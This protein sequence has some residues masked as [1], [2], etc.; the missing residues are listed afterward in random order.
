MRAVVM[1]SFGGEEVLQLTEVADPPAAPGEAL[2]RVGAVEVS[3]TRDIA[4]RTGRHPFSA[5]VSLPHVLGGDFTGTVEAIGPG[6]SPELLGRRVAVANSTG[7]GRCPACRAGREDQCPQLRMLGIHRWGS[8]AEIVSTPAASLSPIPDDLPLATAAAMAATGPIALTQLRTGGV[9]AGSWLVVTGASGAL[10]TMLAVLARH[11]G[12]RVIGLSRRPA[13]IPADAGLAV[14]LDSE[15]DDLADAI[16]AHTG[17]AGADAVMENV[18]DGDTFTRY[19]PALAIGARIVVSGAVGA[20]PPPILPVPA[21][22]FYVRSLSLLGVRTTNR[23]DID[24]FWRLV[25][26]GLRLPEGLVTQWP[27]ADAA[28]D[29]R[30]D[31]PRRHRRPHRAAGRRVTTTA[32]DL[33]DVAIVGYG[34]TGMTLAALLGAQGHRVVVVDRFTE[35][36]N[37]PRAAC[38]DDEIMRTFQKLDLVTDVLP[39][40]VVQ[41]DYDWINGNGDTLLSVTYDNPARCGWAALYMMYQPD[42]ETVLDRRCRELASVEVRQGLTV[43][44]IEL[45]DEQVRLAGTDAN[46]RRHRIRARFAIG[47]DGGSGFVRAALGVELSDLGFAENWLVCDFRARHPLDDVP[48]FRQVCDPAQPTSIVRIGPHHRRFS[49]MLEP[50]ETREEAT[51]HERVWHRVA[52]Y[53]G[54]EDAELVRVANYVFRSRIAERWR[55]GRALLAGDAAHEM[56]PFLA[57]GM[58]SG[59]RDSHNIAWKLDLVLRGLASDA[60]LDTYQPE[61]EPHVR[62]ITGK[63]IELGR[64]QTLRDVEAARRRDERMLAQRQAMTEPD[65]IIYPPLGDGLLAADGPAGELFPQGRVRAPDGQVGLFDDIVGPGPCIVVRDAAALLALGIEGRERWDRLGGRL[66]LVGDGDGDGAG[67]G[68]GVGGLVDLDG[69]YERWFGRHEVVAAVVR[70][71]WYVYGAAADGAE[72]TAVVAQL[73]HGLHALVPESATGLR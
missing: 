43:D 69:I 21:Q 15:R 2:V 27:L 54:P 68:V 12:A 58:C 22:P 13:R 63:A 39:G 6:V 44:G 8:Y 30:A 3:S 49:F 35:L 5:Q 18:S 31:R 62:F 17:S 10:A 7:C 55:V 66:A 9:T 50:G 51:R 71:D 14:A 61:R 23:E 65:K 26:E 32:D 64:V 16:R 20:E 41:T 47:A 19:L 57:Q 38:F 72:L 37:L 4:T 24:R 42:V 59:I 48:T 53:I 60:V 70:P 45:V 29:T 67:D 46:G 40:T 36:Y 52:P 73:H 25:H 28:R 11:L 34:P 33:V 1:E 56:P